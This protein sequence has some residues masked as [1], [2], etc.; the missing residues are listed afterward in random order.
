MNLFI[1]DLLIS[2]WI[3]AWYILY[4]FKITK[5]NPKIWI[6][7]ILFVIFIMGL[8]LLYHKKYI[9]F[10]TFGIINIIIKVIPLLTLYN[11]P[12]MIVDFFAGLLLFIVY[13]GWVLYN[14]ETIF[15]I[16]SKIMNSLLYDNKSIM[17]YLTPMKFSSIK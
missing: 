5:Y 17:Y 9:L 7:I 8:I 1:T 3:F 15:T 4:I 2:Y 11:S 10:I 6:I 12:I 13:N 16:Y 14:N